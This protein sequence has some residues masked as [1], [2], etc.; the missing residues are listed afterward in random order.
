[1]LRSWSWTFPDMHSADPTPSTILETSTHA[2][3]LVNTQKLSVWM[4]PAL[5]DGRVTSFSG[6]LSSYHHVNL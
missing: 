2:P 4:Q 6:A 3:E 1:M 5:Q